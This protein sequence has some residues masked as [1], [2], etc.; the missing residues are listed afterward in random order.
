MAGVNSKDFKE[1]DS[2][3]AKCKLNT[4]EYK[5]A[6]SRTDKL[7]GQPEMDCNMGSNE[8][9]PECDTTSDKSGPECDMGSDKSGPECDI[10]SGESRPECNIGSDEHRLECGTGFDKFE[11]TVGPDQNATSNLNMSTEG[12]TIAQGEEGFEMSRHII[13]PKY[14]GSEE[15]ENHNTK[16]DESTHEAKVYS[17]IKSDDSRILAEPNETTKTSETDN[18][19]AAMEESTNYIATT[20]KVPGT[21]VAKG[22]RKGQN[23]RSTRMGGTSPP[24]ADLVL[25]NSSPV[26]CKKKRPASGTFALGPIIKKPK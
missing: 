3:S 8:F 6:V 4:A 9:K 14:R 2:I 26:I 23:L 24:I 25:P 10:G 15:V 19:L 17:N 20:P 7:T 13:S 18:K 21:V 12:H 1:E 11:I 16:S 5:G 22:E